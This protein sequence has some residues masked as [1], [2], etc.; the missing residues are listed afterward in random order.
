[1]SPINF[2]ASWNCSWLP[3]WNGQR[4]SWFNQSAPCLTGPSRYGNVHLRSN[5]KKLR[6]PVGIVFVGDKAVDLRANAVAA[7]AA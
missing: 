1:M 4:V 2:E 6:L 7:N 5:G 3:V